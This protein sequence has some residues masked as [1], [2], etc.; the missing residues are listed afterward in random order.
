MALLQSPF[1]NILSDN[2]VAL[3]ETN[4]RPADTRWFPAVA[5]EI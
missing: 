3:L 2:Q 4:D 1:L 5:R